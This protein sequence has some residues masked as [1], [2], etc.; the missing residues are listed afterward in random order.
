MTFEEW[1]NATSASNK[2]KKE[3]AEEAWNMASLQ[4]KKFLNEIL[5][6]LE[7]HNNNLREIIKM[8]KQQACISL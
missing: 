6:G 1:W 2:S 7:T 4:N 8:R 3:L 5:C